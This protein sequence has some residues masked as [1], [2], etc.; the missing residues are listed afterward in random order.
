LITQR[1]HGAIQSQRRIA[2]FYGWARPRVGGF[3]IWMFGVVA[4]VR[5]CVVDGRCEACAEL[6]LPWAVLMGAGAWRYRAV[7][8][9]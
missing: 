8:S 4:S 3:L 2:D 9:R 5:R 6:V 1:T 7:P